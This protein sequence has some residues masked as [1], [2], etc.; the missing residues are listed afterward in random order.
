METTTRQKKKPNVTMN[1]QEDEDEEYIETDE[2]LEYSEEEYIDDADEPVDKSEIAWLLQDTEYANKSSTERALDVV[3]SYWEM[4]QPLLKI[5]YIMVVLLALG[6][7]LMIITARNKNGYC[8]SENVIE[9]ETTLSKSPIEKF[10]SLST[11]CIPCPDHGNCMHGD[12][13][14]L[15]LYKRR[16]ALYN[17]FG[18]LPV[19]DECIQDSAIGRAVYRAE[20]RIKNALAYRQGQHVCDYVLRFGTDE[21]LAMVHTKASDVRQV[22]EERYRTQS[23][24]TK[25]KLD[26]VLDSAFISLA[27]D[28][29]IHYWEIDGESY[30]G[31]ERASFSTYCTIRILAGI[32]IL[33]FGW[34]NH[35]WHTK[36]RKETDAKVSQVITQLKE[37][38]EKHLSDPNHIDR[39]LPVSKLR[40]SLT[41]V[42]KPGSV[43]EWKRI[44]HGVQSHPQI[45]RSFQEVAGEP[46]EYWELAH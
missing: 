14:C 25:E 35:M 31:T 41:D 45:R 3:Q 17:P 9:K 23:K 13:H 10:L 37:Q 15:G 22:V 5:I 1:Y 44:A 43:D 39:G 16:H 46:S 34:Y 12:L 11:S 38:F 6:S 8:N 20:K 36:V 7:T 27:T 26:Q 42:N 2:E 18:I 24:W 19:A 40:V 30:F 4:L 32:P 33:S 21:G 29:K 28:P